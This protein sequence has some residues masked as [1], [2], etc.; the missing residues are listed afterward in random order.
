[1]DATDQPISPSAPRPVSSEFRPRTADL[2]PRI[3][4]SGFFLHASA[5]VVDGGAVLFL[6]HSTAGKSTMAR[7]LGTKCPVLADDAVHVTRCGRSEWRVVDGSFRFE[8]D[9]R[10]EDWSRELS[11]RAGAG[12]VRLK[13]CCRLHKA[14]ELRMERMAPIE[15]ARH[16][17]DAVMEMDLQR[18][19]G[20][21]QGGGGGAGAVQ[22]DVLQLRK[23]WFN[24][25]SDIA[26]RVPGWHLWF[27]KQTEA[28]RILQCMEEAIR[29]AEI[30]NCLQHK[31]V[32]PV[33]RAAT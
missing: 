20:K 28:G 15:L 19:A 25:A 17:M 29:G 4:D 26:R 24:E 12:A 21:R 8:N 18:K 16:V 33:R 6:G 10:L 23:R 5:V 11:R 2:G 7:L 3:P 32:A 14:P 30:H 1:M 22:S 27:H 13:A 9:G 31:L